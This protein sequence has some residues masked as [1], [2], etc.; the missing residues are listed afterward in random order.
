MLLQCT[1]T[2]AAETSARVSSRLLIKTLLPAIAST[3][4]TRSS[5][6][7]YSSNSAT[8]SVSATENIP[9]DIDAPLPRDSNNANKASSSF[10][11]Q[12]QRL[13]T[14]MDMLHQIQD[15]PTEKLDITPL[16]DQEAHYWAR[17]MNSAILDLGQEHRTRLRVA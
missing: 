8:A 11:V 9:D 1:R 17:R 15:A 12:K 7:V 14:S 4:S 6:V 13:L 16:D 5:Q 3:A 2:K 10:D